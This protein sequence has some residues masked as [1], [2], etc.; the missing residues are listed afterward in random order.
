[1]LVNLLGFRQ[2]DFV[3]Q[4]GNVVKGT[5]MYVSHQETGVTGVMTDKLFIKP[6]I[7]MPEGLKVGKPFHVYFNKRGKVEAISL[8]E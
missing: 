5:T 1:M 2:L 6:E 8:S 4:D 3:G 7:P